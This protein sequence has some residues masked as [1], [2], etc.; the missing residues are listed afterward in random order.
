L[1]WDYQKILDYK[2]EQ[3]E[4]IPKDIL[5]EIMKPSP[6]RLDGE[7]QV[8]LYICTKAI[9]EIGSKSKR[10]ST[11]ETI[12]PL[13]VPEDL[14]DATPFN[15]FFFFGLQTTHLSFFSVK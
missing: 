3:A 11:Q 13:F 9:W 5:D 7:V 14:T 12:D 15:C 2:K 1:N 6:M 10:N 4:H 8:W